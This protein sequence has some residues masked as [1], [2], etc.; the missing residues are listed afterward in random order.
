M[1]AVL[2]SV[3]LPAKLASTKQLLICRHGFA[4]VSYQGT[5]SGVP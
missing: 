4:A 5:P 2:E 1:L 3:P